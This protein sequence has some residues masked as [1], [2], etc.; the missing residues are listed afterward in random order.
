M[1]KSEG[2]LTKTQFIKQKGD[3]P[4]SQK[5]RGPKAINT[6]VA[7][8]ATSQTALAVPRSLHTV[9]TVT[10]LYS[11]VY[12]PFQ[13]ALPCTISLERVHTRRLA[14]STL[15]LQPRNL[16]PFREVQ[17]C[18]FPGIQTGSSLPRPES[19]A[20]ESNMNAFLVHQTLPEKKKNEEFLA[21]A[22]NNLAPKS[23]GQ[24]HFWGQ[25]TPTPTYSRC[26]SDTQEYIQSLE[27][28]G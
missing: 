8:P 28:G 18:K 20:P 22:M 21:S 13:R 10:S 24:S 2:G 19:G 3:L 4:N 23:N 25:S 12:F 15:L 1:V 27:V 17:Q 14:G 9:T 7:T 26:L 6:I 5:H 11:H 16:S